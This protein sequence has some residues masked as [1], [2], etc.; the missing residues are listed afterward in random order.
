MKVKLNQHVCY[1]MFS[2]SVAIFMRKVTAKMEGNCGMGETTLS[3]KLRLNG[4]RY[5]KSIFPE[6]GVRPREPQHAYALSAFKD[7]TRQVL[8]NS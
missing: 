8:Q 6:S 2:V 1:I 4:K 5:V 7:R 3:N